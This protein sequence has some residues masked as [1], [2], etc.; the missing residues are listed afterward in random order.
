MKITKRYKLI[1][2]D[3]DGTLADSSPVILPAF[4]ETF[5][6]FGIKETNSQKLK[7]TIGHTLIGIYKNTYGLKGKQLAQ[8]LIYH[9]QMVFKRRKSYRLYPGVRQT[10]LT[11]KKSGVLLAIATTRL[12]KVAKTLPKMLNIDF[13]DHIEGMTNKQVSSDKQILLKK[14]VKRYSNIPKSQILIVGDRNVDILAAKK[15]GAHSA[16]ALYG[17]GS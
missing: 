1:I 8:A 16:A 15:T 4:K 3:F 12:N 13:F 14:I 9:R 2:F 6:K 17:F 7:A 11:L 10:L 5:K